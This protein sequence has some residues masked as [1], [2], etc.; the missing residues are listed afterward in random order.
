MQILVEKPFEQLRGHGGGL[1]GAWRCLQR[2]KEGK[3]CRRV[4]LSYAKIIIH[5]A[6]DHGVRRIKNEIR[7]SSNTHHQ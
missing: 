5:I 3:P 6:V 4:E 1:I 2:D 7:D